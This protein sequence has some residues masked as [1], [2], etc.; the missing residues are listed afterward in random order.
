M[1]IEY[2]DDGGSPWMVVDEVKDIYVSFYTREEAEAYILGRQ[3]EREYI[4]GIIENFA[5]S[6]TRLPPKFE[7]VLNENLSRLY[8]N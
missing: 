2:I 1:K 3:E 5:N 4:S 6:Q 8:K 7:K